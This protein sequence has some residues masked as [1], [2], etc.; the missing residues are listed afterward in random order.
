MKFSRK[1]FIFLQL[2]DFSMKSAFD[3]CFKSQTQCVGFGRNWSHFRPIIL[4]FHHYPFPDPTLWL[5]MWRKCQSWDHETELKKSGRD[6]FESKGFAFKA[7]ILCLYYKIDFDLFFYS[8]PHLNPELDSTLCQLP[9]RMYYSRLAVNLFLQAIF[10]FVFS[11]KFALLFSFL[12]YIYF[13]R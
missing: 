7:T 2:M 10:R 6:C 5:S 4:N 8:D 11:K 3:R 12:C 1:P 9:E 13:F